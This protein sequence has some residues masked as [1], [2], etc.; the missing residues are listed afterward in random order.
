MILLPVHDDIH[1]EFAARG[2]PG[3][4]PTQAQQDHRENA[5]RQIEHLAQF[6]KTLQ[7]GA[8]V[9]RAQ[10]DGIGRGANV[11]GGD[12]GILEGYPEVAKRSG[13][14]ERRR[15]DSGPAL[16]PV[17][18][19]AEEKIRRRGADKILV[20]HLRHPQLRL[21]LIDPNNRIRL[22]I[23]AGGGMDPGLKHLLQGLGR[24]LAIMKTAATRAFQKQTHGLVGRPGHGII[25]RTVMGG[26]LAIG[27]YSPYD[28]IGSFVYAYADY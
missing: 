3:L 8:D 1:T 21:R 12:Y 14:A 9:H 7:N 6:A 16:Q 11:L 13:G 5:V 28:K 18:V 27:H 25:T 23:A 20:A 26:H 22:E 15:L 10:P 24:N 19:D 4:G 2:R 17:I